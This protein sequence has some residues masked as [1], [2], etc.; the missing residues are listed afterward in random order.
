M[1]LLY[2]VANQKMTE[3]R[4]SFVAEV[5]HRLQADLQ[6][7]VASG[8]AGVFENAKA[9]YEK[10][11][12]VF[13]RSHHQ[14]RFVQGDPIKAMEG[15]LSSEEYDMIVFAVGRRKRLIP[16]QYR[17]L[18]QQVIKKAKAPVLLV[19]RSS[20]LLDR[21]L[22]CTGGLEISEPVVSLSARLAG[23][24][25]M[26][27]TLLT[28]AAPVPS[29]YTGMAEMDETMEELLETDTPLAQH[30]RRSAK[31]LTDNGISSEVKVIH[32]DVVEGILEEA[33]AGNFDL[34]ALGSTEGLT[35]RGILLGNVTQ[36]II[37]RAACAVLVVKNNP[38]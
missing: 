32:G 36:Q 25:G 20:K 4:A 12:H 31:V 13:E 34:V 38:R 5:A 28:V 33:A 30:L 35:L 29:M 24:V 23:K 26:E 2:L 18:S 22:V 16:S 14:A 37:N 11:Q 6:I 7:L 9:S 21:M 1:K 19:R 10:V 15:E 3:S 17:L 8:D 27:A